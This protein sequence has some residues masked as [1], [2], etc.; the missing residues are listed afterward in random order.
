MQ[1]WP[2]TYTPIVG[3][4]Q[5]RYMLNS[6]YAP[7][8]LQKQMESSHQFI[9]G[10]DDELPIA[11][12]SWSE[13]SPGIYK[14]H[15][16]YIVKTQQGR[17]A[18][19]FMIDYIIGELRELGATELRLNVNRYNYPAMAFYEKTGFAKIAE[20]DIDIGNGYFMNDYVLSREIN[21]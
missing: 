14:L 2:Q 6:F 3:A 21:G 12:A 7:E 13:L 10:Y 8:S 18:G 4:E 9:I 19:R 11:F 16:L 20:E 17:G 15:K 1:V 5:V